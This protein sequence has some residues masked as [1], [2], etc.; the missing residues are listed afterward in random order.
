MK[1]I[2]TL[3]VSFACSIGISNSQTTQTF[4]AVTNLNTLTDKCW[5]FLGA[6]LHK[7]PA[8]G[9]TALSVNAASVGG[10][11]WVYAPYA[12]LTSSSTISFTFQ[13]ANKLSAAA[14]RTVSV[15][16]VG[17]DGSQLP[18][19]T[20]TLDDQSV[21]TPY[22]FAGKS[23]VTGV[24]RVVIEIAAA[25]DEA[26]SMYLDNITIGGSFNYNPPYWC[27]DRSNGTTTI[28]HL[29]AFQ[30][31]L[32]SDR[33]HLQWTVAENENNQY[34][35]IERSLD[36]QDFQGIAIVKATSRVA[37]ENYSHQESLQGNAYYRL[38]L[39]SKTGIRMF[40]NVLYFK[41]GSTVPNLSLLQN[42]IQQTLKVGFTAER[43][44]VA[45]VIVYDMSGFKVFQKE[46]QAGKGYNVIVAELNANLKKGLYF[47]E[48][49]QE[50][51][52]RTTKFV[53]E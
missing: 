2:F 17:I 20:I 9:T 28:H 10:K 1:Y 51:N 39:V 40:S 24:R 4:E 46:Y 44:S 38:K 25:G 52:K 49:N 26:T 32:V 47:L 36:G 23:S 37:V 14:T 3:A 31:L 45:T 16:L 21:T 42:P 5:Q 19:G 41:S 33:V 22:T 27:K 53:K 7:T 18:V 11:A 8:A 29:K 50:E 48:I 12:D 6:T 34:F 13:L 30:G 35:E 15:R 43:K